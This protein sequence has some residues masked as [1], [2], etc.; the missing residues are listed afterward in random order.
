MNKLKQ[1][2]YSD[3]RRSCSRARTVLFGLYMI[4]PIPMSIYHSLHNW[5]GI[6]Q[7]V[8]IGLQQLVDSSRTR[9][10]W[11]SFRNNLKLVVVSIGTQLPMRSCWQCS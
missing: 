2:L 8:Y 1:L 9:S 3:S 5:S 6:G 7:R 10:F 4:A 11:L